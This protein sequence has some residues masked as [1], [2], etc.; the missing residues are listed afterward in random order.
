[1]ENPKLSFFSI[2]TPYTAEAFAIQKSLFSKEKSKNLFIFQKEKLIC[3]LHCHLLDEEFET[4]LSLFESNQIGIPEELNAGLVEVVVNYFYFKEISPIALKDLFHFFQLSFFMK[5]EPITMEI[6][7]FLNGNLID[8]SRATIIYKGVFEFAYFFKEDC[9]KLIN[10][11]IEK[12]IVFFMKN[13]YLIEF[14][15]IFD[16]CFFEN[17]KES[18]KEMFFSILNSL[19]VCKAPNEIILKIR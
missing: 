1:M 19:K 7:R 18:L 5:V 4:S 11:L 17:M 2:K 16:Q 8:I 14:F 13:N 10:P 15:I 9:L 3:K 6:L 12:C